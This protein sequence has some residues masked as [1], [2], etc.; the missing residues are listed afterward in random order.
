MPF[1]L[2]RAPEF[3]TTTKGRYSMDYRTVFVTTAGDDEARR[4]GRV[5][6]EERL[7]ACVNIVD[8]IRSLYWWR[9]AIQED[10]EAAF[11]AKTRAELVER[12]I[13]RVQELHSY[14]CPCVVSWPIMDGNPSFL[15]WIAD[16]TD[17]R[18][19]PTS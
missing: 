16:T 5:L 11:V 1:V 18:K 8:R 14:E 7:V 4:I 6:L 13:A 2:S 10:E 12:V 15:Q 9:E 3:T 19:N 17:E